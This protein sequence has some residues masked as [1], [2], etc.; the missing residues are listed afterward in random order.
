MK[1]K[2]T[3]LVTGASKGLGKALSLTLARRGYA[4]VMV[5]RGEQALER[6][7]G[8]VE[9]AGGAATGLAYDVADKEAVHRIAQLAAALHGEV[10]IVVHN[11]STLGPVPM[12]LLLDLACEDLEA[13]LAT[14]LVGPFRLTKALA[15]PMALRGSG[16]VVFVSSDAAVQAYPGWG[17]YGATKAAADHL[18]RT[19]AAELA[20]HGVR[21]LSVDPGEMDTDMHAD[22]L[23]D[24]DRSAL[25]RPEDVAE[26]IVQMI[27]DVRRAPSGAR[28]EVSSWSHDGALERAS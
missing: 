8:E 4:V 27:E 13:V 18:A 6:A 21:V 25:A 14:N 20:D 28:L 15:G 5:A 24:A 9:A 7:V 26:R 12:P 11:A 23:P 2:K 16:T 22:A 19:L 17:A 3:A 1:T 10:D